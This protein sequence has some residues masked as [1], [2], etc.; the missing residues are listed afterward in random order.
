MTNYCQTKNKSCTHANEYGQCNITACTESIRTL[1]IDPNAAVQYQRYEMNFTEETKEFLKELV[2]PNSNSK[3]ILYAYAEPNQMV[4]HVFTDD[5]AITY[6][7]SKDEAISKFK[8]YYGNAD[9]SNVCEITIWTENGIAI[10]T[11]Y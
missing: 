7:S 6:A 8:V 5:V 3:N 11:S 10:L 9:D 1:K 2:H 4:D